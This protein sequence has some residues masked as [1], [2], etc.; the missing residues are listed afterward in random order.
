MSRIKDT[1]EHSAFEGPAIGSL[2][3]ENYV[4]IE[5]KDGTI[6]YEPP[7]NTD[8]KESEIMNSLRN[9]IK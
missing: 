1:P 7:Q 8:T 6:S 3:P 2:I 9:N 4:R 5:H